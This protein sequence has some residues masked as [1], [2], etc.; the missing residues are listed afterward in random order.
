MMEGI[1]FLEKYGGDGDFEM[2]MKK[3]VWII[4]CLL[5]AL[6]SGCAKNQKEE[7]AKQ[8]KVITVWTY[9]NGAQKESFDTLVRQFNETEGAG[10]GIMVESVSKGTIDEL[11][12]A[13]ADSADKK[14]GSDPL[15]Q[16]CAAYADNAFAIN[17][18]GLVADLSPYLTEEEMDTYV[19]AYL[20]EGRFEAENTLKLFP[21]AKSTEV[22]TVNMTDWEKFASETGA[23]LGELS[24]WE[25]VARVAER[26]YE[27]SGGRAFFGRD[28]FANYMLIGSYQLGHEIF[29]MEGGSMVLD[30]DKDTMR[31]LWDCYYVPY[32]KGHYTAGGKF[33]SDDL[34]TGNLIAF[35]GSTSGAT[36]T[37]N[38]VTYEDGTSYEI[39]CR[40]LPLPGFEGTRP[41]AVQQGAGM[42]VLKSG[43]ELEEAAVAFLK[44]FAGEE[45][46]L[47]F[48][49]RS[50][51]LPVKKSANTPEALQRVIDEKQIQVSEIMRE[52]LQ[53]GIE[54]VQTYDLYTTKAFAGGDKA[55]AILEYG[56]PERAKEDREAVEEL[57]AG[58]METEEALSKYLTEE[59]FAQWYDETYRKLTALGE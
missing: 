47:E 14:V 38:T 40:I 26:Y 12:Q 35:A 43:Q 4:S 20:E 41:A 21:T 32:V 7:A 1:S 11:S 54:E 48:S 31:R 30:F 34:K 44:W 55:R 19:D 45:Q 16:I 23:S 42:M 49:V 22:L 28:A 59:R 37:P 2:K 36:Y 51:Y 58:G 9:Y 17:Q 24:T 3:C 13:I 15:P 18:K 6:L 53:V 10:Q 5:M 50:G 52:S 8:P 56:M 33:R 39:T 29:R 57:I 25:G 46:N 27:W